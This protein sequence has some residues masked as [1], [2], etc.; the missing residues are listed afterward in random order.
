MPTYTTTEIYT[1]GHVQIRKQGSYGADK[2][3]IISETIPLPLRCLQCSC[4]SAMNFTD[5][6][7]TSSDFESSSIAAVPASHMRELD[8]HIQALSLKAMSDRDFAR[9]RG[10][11]LKALRRTV[12]RFED[13][14]SFRARLV[15][16]A[17]FEE[18][19]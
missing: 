3:R 6:S 19:F 16:L 12:R 2:D 13:V 18:E 7:L 4:A 14:D 8:S 11:E 15:K 1:C 10:R 17:A 5:P 9:G